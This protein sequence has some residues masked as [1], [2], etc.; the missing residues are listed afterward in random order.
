M[1]QKDAPTWMG[2]Q[3]YLRITA[4]VSAIDDDAKKSHAYLNAAVDFLDV[5][6][7]E[8]PDRGAADHGPGR[9]VKSGAVALT[10]DRPPLQQAG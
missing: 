5:V 4:L 10:H 7:V 1:T 2:A 6:H 3:V 9:D 8:G